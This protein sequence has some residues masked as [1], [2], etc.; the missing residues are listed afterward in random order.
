MTG[1]LSIP[2]ELNYLPKE[3]L[4]LAKNPNSSICLFDSRSFF[5]FFFFF[6]SFFG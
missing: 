1:F 2:L 3:E 6:D 4:V 5:F